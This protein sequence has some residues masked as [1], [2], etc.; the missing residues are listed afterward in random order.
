MTEIEQIKK[1]MA[2]LKKY[3]EGFD[4]LSEGSKKFFSSEMLELRKKMLA[5]IDKI[6]SLFEKNANYESQILPLVKEVGLDFKKYI[7]DTIDIV[8]DWAE[9]IMTNAERARKEEGGSLVF[10]L[11][12]IHTKA[13][14]LYREMVRYRYEEKPTVG[15]AREMGGKMARGVAEVFRE[16]FTQIALLETGNEKGRLKEEIEMA[17]RGKEDVERFLSELPKNPA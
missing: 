2:D 17:K 13:E 1:E 3:L 16:I 4:D 10:G 14:K 5:N 12:L 6:L 7:D 15:L 8:L 9:S 11:K